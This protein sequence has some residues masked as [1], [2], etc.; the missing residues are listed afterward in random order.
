MEDKQIVDLYWERS[1][2]AIEE[3]GRKYGSMLQR[4]SQSI[5]RVKED[6][7]ECVNDSYVSAW[8]SMPENRP[9]YLGAYMAK[10]VRNLSLNL[11]E[12]SNAVKRKADLVPLE[13][14]E[15]CISDSD[16]PS[17][18]GEEGRI[19]GVINEF[20]AAL[21]ED[22]R[23]IFVRRYFFNDSEEEIA[24]TFRLGKGNVRVILY[25]MRLGLKNRLK[26]AG[27]L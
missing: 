4:L 25:R 20:L 18:W 23:K 6:A 8:N 24:D 13:E 19:Q 10:I 21:P 11:V 12:K 16:D 5:L 27:L 14:L 17:R 7:E 3:T 22:K 15:E 9:T 2:R 1:E 26:E